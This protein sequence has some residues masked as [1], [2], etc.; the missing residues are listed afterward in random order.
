VTVYS[1]G[2]GH[3]LAVIKSL[4]LSDGITVNSVSVRSCS[5][6]VETLASVTPS[7]ISNQVRRSIEAPVNPDIPFALDYFLVTQTTHVCD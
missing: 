7:L 2:E 4:L 6:E 3:S 1:S 5:T